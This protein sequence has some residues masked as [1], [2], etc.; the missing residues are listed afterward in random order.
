MTEARARRI[1]PPAPLIERITGTVA[2]AG[3]TLA[4]A[5][6]MLVTTSVLLRW[7]AGTPIEGDFEYV[8]MATA[9]AVFCF[10]PY[11]Q[12]CRSNISADVFTRRLPLH[13]QRAIDSVW[14]LAYAGMTG[15]LAVALGFGAR[16]A[17]RSG[18]T[19]MQTQTPLWP[20]IAL[21]ALLCGLL[22]VTALITADRLRRAAQGRAAP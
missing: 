17:L 7:L 2:V 3:G 21:S 19:T 4:L 12:A 14:D 1:E 8:K 10:L 15:F 13:L 5:T 9:I 22:A 11:T 16:D 18:V 6:A 20:G